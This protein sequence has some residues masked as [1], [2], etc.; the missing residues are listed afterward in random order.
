M[1]APSSTPTPSPQEHEVHALTR[2]PPALV[3]K[4]ISSLK[5]VL[6][7]DKG[8]GVAALAGPLRDRLQAVANNTPSAMEAD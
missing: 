7:T 6:E 1:A 4:A 8:A 3:K 5:Q 2:L